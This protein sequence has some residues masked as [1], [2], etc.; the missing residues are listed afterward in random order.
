MPKGHRDTEGVRVIEQAER[1]KQT[2]AEGEEP[3]PVTAAVETKQTILKEK[4]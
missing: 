3:L 4:P 1:G 2:H